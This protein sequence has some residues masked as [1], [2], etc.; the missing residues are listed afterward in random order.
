MISLAVLNGCETGMV[1]GDDI[2]DGVA[3][4]LVKQG[5]PA[6]VAATRII[7]DEPAMLFSR[8]FYRALSDG[9]HVEASLVEA[10]KSLDTRRLDW[11]AYALFTRSQDLHKIRLIR[12]V[13]GRNAEFP[14]AEAL[15]RALGDSSA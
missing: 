8:E 4:S 7:E 1:A 9:Y 3:Q 2:I 11:S 14:G 12:P 13:G 10:R 15:S 6:V 5:I